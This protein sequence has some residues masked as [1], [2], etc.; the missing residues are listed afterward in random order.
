MIHLRIHSPRL[1]EVY[2]YI[3]HEHGYDKNE[4][5][6]LPSCLI[7]RI[8]GNSNLHKGSEVLCIPSFHRIKWLEGSSYNQKDTTFEVPV[9]QYFIFFPDY[10]CFMRLLT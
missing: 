10:G 6:T 2:E 9:L 8:I 7:Q 3:E 5:Y 4:Q 1:Q